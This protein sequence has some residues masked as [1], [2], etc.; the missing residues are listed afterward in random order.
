MLDI[1]AAETDVLVLGGGFAGRRAAV[2]AAEAGASVGLAFLARGASPFVIAVN[3]PLGHAD[4]R[5]S[6][7]VYFDDMLSGGYGLNDRRLVRVLADHSVEA[8]DELVALGVAFARD[9][10]GYRQRHL[11]G[12]TYPRSVFIP[13]GIGGALL[14]RLE[15]RLAALGARLWSGWKV[16]DLLRDGTQVVGA[17]LA[18]RHAGRLLAVRARS[19]VIAMGGI[20]QLYEDSTYPTDVAADAYA[21]AY[22]AGA[23]LIDMEF[24]QFEPLVTVHPAGCRGMEMPTAM[25]GDGARLLNVDG[26]RFMQRYNPEHG[27]KRIEKARLSLCIQREIDAGRGLADGTVLLDTTAMGSDQLESY[28]SHCRRLRAAGLDPATGMVE[29]RPA[30]HSE[31]G[32]IFIDESGWTGVAGLYAGG[33]AAGGIHGA[34][35]LAGNGGGETVVFGGLVG[36]G[37][38]AGM[39]EARKRDWARIEAAA[40]APIQA[41]IDAHGE[42]EP[43]AIKTALRAIMS[44]TAGLYR[45]EAGLRQGIE[46]LAALQGQIEAGLRAQDLGGAIAAREA[47]NMVLAARMI[48]MAALARTESRGAHQRRDFPEQDDAHWLEHVVCSRGRDGALA[49]GKLAI[50]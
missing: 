11:S 2:A 10:E 5:D 50:H 9:G 1:E 3:I 28:V 4:P 14:D 42:V 38:V 44:R 25:M 27:E 24:V 30:A 13:E 33:E 20:G 46:E 39:L 17:L 19:T 21:L 40:A 37:A 12:N 7:E 32:G 23:R 26:E 43:E 18:E 47:R 49:L 34:S 36:R 41:A 22:D 48:T 29:V 6:P 16:L 31:M 15:E 45:D 35:R 8:F